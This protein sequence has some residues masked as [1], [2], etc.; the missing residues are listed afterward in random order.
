MIAAKALLRAAGLAADRAGTAAVEF[1]I[2]LPVLLLLFIGSYE[3]ANLLLAYHK[4]ESAAETTAGLVA[5]VPAGTVVLASGSGTGWDFGN[6]SAAADEVMTPFPTTGIKMA[7]ASITYSTGAAV[8]DWHLEQNGATPINVASLPDGVQ[9]ANLGTA[10]SGSSSS[11]VVVQ[12]VY[13]YT[14]PLSSFLNTNYTLTVTAF[15]RPRYVNCVPSYLNT[16]PST[17]SS[18]PSTCTCP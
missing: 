7:Y 4:L 13:P 2:L 10:S 12:L 17:C 16:T 9:T 14:S 8:I 5:E 6:I 11:A 18:T 3:F 1:A 15:N